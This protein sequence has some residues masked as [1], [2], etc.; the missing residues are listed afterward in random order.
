MKRK[1]G[2]RYRKVFKFKTITRKLIKEYDID[3]IYLYLMC[4]LLYMTG[5]EAGQTAERSNP[6]NG[7]MMQVYGY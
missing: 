4:S 7:A 2:K 3:K 6:P 1:S 5:P